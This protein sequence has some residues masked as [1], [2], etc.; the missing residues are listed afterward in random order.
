[1]VTGA[2]SIDFSRLFGPENLENFGGA[3][4]KG[5]FILIPI[6]PFKSTMAESRSALDFPPEGGYTD[7]S[8]AGGYREG[9]WSICSLM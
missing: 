5:T 8:P 2:K 4:S 1:M 9:I 3:P 7:I 6:D